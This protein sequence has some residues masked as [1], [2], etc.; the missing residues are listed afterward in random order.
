VVQV[1]GSGSE[2]PGS[3]LRLP[4]QASRHGHRGTG[5]APPAPAPAHPG[6]GSLPHGPRRQSRLSRPP[7]H[8]RRCV[9]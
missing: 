5:I 3:P 2:H 4:D 7:R 9:M 1:S 8:R 6:P